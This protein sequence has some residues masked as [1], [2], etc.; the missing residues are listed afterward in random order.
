MKYILIILSLV[1]LLC[2]SG[3][4]IVEKRPLDI[5]T[6]IQ[7]TANTWS[8]EFQKG[9]N[10]VNVTVTQQPSKII[11]YSEVL[12][13]INFVCRDEI[14]EERTDLN[15][16]VIASTGIINEKRVNE[17]TTIYYP[18]LIPVL[19]NYRINL[20][21]NKRYDCIILPDFRYPYAL[22]QDGVLISNSSYYCDGSL[23]RVG[24]DCYEP[25]ECYITNKGDFDNYIYKLIRDCFVDQPQRY[26]R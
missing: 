11:K 25:N 12:L 9:T 1:S 14:N 7:G 3:C 17:F 8:T 18:D 23:F 5:N 20:T 24:I 19:V 4:V 21:K 26:W 16:S 22:Y 6:N 13:P 10:E 15:Y 2:F